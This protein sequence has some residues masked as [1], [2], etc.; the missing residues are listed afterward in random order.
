MK[1]NTPKTPQTA[2]KVWNPTKIILGHVLPFIGFV[3]GILIIMYFSS[4]YE[5]SHAQE[6]EVLRKKA[7][8]VALLWMDL[9]E[10]LTYPA[11]YLLTQNYSL[12]EKFKDVEWKIEADMLTLKE[13]KVVPPAVYNTIDSLWQDAYSLALDIFHSPPPFSEEVMKNAQRF[14][15]IVR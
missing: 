7:R 15:S 2:I 9:Y 11:N 4:R 5:L 13:Q 1:N 6:E 12:L 3:G 14:K 8:A 10:A